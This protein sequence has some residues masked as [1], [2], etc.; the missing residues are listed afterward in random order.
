M[1][2]GLHDI[3]AVAAEFLGPEICRQEIE[4][5]NLLWRQLAGRAPTTPSF[6]FRRRQ[7]PWLKVAEAV[8]LKVGGGQSCEESSQEWK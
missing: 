2:A 7:D 1:Q 4:M 3:Q 5:M 8:R 6:R